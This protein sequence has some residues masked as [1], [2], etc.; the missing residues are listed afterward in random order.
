MIKLCVISGRIIECLKDVAVT[1]FKG[2]LDTCSEMPSYELCCVRNGKNRK[3][4]V[5]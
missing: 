3:S 5:S 4:V 2:I 1:I